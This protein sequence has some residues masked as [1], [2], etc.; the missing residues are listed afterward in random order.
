MPSR[1]GSFLGG[2]S[3]GASSGLPTI[4]Y[5]KLH[6]YQVGSFSPFAPICV[7]F[8]QIVLRVPVA[9]LTAFF[10][11]L[12][13]FLPV[14]GAEALV[15]WNPLCVRSANLASFVL[16]SAIAKLSSAFNKRFCLFADVDRALHS[17]NMELE[18]VVMAYAAVQC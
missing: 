8:V 5:S 6:D 4:D 3:G 16:A 9:Q 13:H 17:P 1:F 11:Y 15:H 10:T 12:H 2:S 14:F 7:N 18:R